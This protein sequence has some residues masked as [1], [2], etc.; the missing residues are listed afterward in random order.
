[1][2]KIRAAI[3]IL[4]LLF[5]HIDVFA[6]ESDCPHM[7]MVC[8]DTVKSD[9]TFDIYIK[10]SGNL[11]VCGGSF[12]VVYNANRIGLVDIVPEKALNNYSF[13][14][15][16]DAADKIKISWYG[17]E[18]MSAEGN[19][20]KLT[21]KAYAAD[22]DITTAIDLENVKLIDSSE[23]P[24]DCSASGKTIKILKTEA[25]IMRVTGK[26]TAVIG[27]TYSATVSVDKNPDAYGGSFIVTYD[28]TKMKVKSVE[29]GA[30]LADVTPFINTHFADNMIKASWASAYPMIGK[31]DLLTINFEVFSGN[32]TDSEIGLEQ[33]LFADGDSNK[34]KCDSVNKPI[35]IS[36]TAVCFTKTVLLKDEKT[37]VSNIYNCPESGTFIVA[38]YKDNVLVGT[39]F[40][41]VGNI[42]EMKYK[43]DYPAFNHIKIMIWEDMHSVR[44]L[45]GCENLDCSVGF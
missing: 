16:I 5:V 17:N 4:V 18:P 23:N 43:Y 25:R 41:A 3:L 11:N 31:G 29:R 19:I 6:Q 22:S 30:L 21:F 28:N 12:C 13:S 14:D 27:T 45:T 26:S 10:M 39:S 35:N 20:V 7:E 33:C 1:M 42:A 44:P 2:K 8:S 38:F 15:K 32:L 37:V 24:I 40:E 9:E 34:Y 36:D